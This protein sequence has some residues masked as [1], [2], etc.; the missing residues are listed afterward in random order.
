MAKKSKTLKLAELQ[1]AYLEVNDPKL[2]KRRQRAAQDYKLTL[3]VP[4]ELVSV[5]PV[6]EKQMVFVRDKF[7]HKFGKWRQFHNANPA[8][9]KLQALQYTGITAP[10]SAWHGVSLSFADR[11]MA[12]DLPANVDRKPRKQKV[13]A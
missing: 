8:V 13:A 1:T 3:F 10:L 6:G 2:L 11:T 4:S 9:E 5:R 12:G 7:G